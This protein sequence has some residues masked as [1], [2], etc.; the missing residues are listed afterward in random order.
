MPKVT[1]QVG[2]PS[3]A[4]PP[5][6]LPPPAPPALRE[7]RSEGGGG[8]EAGQ[9]LPTP[10]RPLLAGVAACVS[11]AC[12]GARGQGFNFLPLLPVLS[13]PRKSCVYDSRFGTFAMADNG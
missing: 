5:L 8:S 7:S 12:K 2:D 9:T 13:L 1:R 4:L 11:R 10:R 3:L 6:V